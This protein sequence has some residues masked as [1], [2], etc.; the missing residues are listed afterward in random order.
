MRIGFSFNKSKS[1]PSFFMK[2]L[3]DA[4]DRKQFCKT[5][6]YLNPFNSA[7]IFANKAKLGS[8]KSFFFRVDGI[9]YD[10]KI[11]YQKRMI[12]NKDLIY[13]LEYSS[14][15]IFQS[16]FSKR[17]VSNILNI[18]PKKFTTI[19]N[20]TDLNFFQNRTN[21]LRINYNVDYDSLVFI[22]SAKWRSHKRLVSIVESFQIFKSNTD[23]KCNLIIIGDHS[24]DF[25]RDK[26]IISIGR[27]DREILPD[28]LSMGDIYLFYSWLDNCPNS[29]IE[30]IA[31][32]L[33]V[34][35]TNQG[36]TREIVEK[37]NGG[38]VVRADDDFNFQPIEL[39]NPPKPNI[40]LIVNSMYEM[41][42]NLDFYKQRINTKS[43]DINF[44][45]SEYFNFIKE[46]LN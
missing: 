11:N 30:A 2:E 3:K 10:S 25:S 46:C 12:L 35:C 8:I 20:G 42:D 31:C 6:L 38:I 45:A 18:K 16:E 23:R 4:L 13:G 43:I 27:V 21:F 15:V 40:E 32:N 41:S 28:V 17:L 24:L 44:V 19:I 39:Y 9:L 7:N 26:S 29:V 5:S 14:G 33:P 37:T 22:T 36:G 34:I 1:G